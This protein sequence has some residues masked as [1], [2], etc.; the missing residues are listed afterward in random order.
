MKSFEILDQA[1]ARDTECHKP[2]V[3]A[4]IDI[5][6]MFYEESVSYLKRLEN[7]DK[8]RHTKGP[9]L[10]SPPVDIKEYA[11]LLPIV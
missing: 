4:N 2:M 5:F 10:A 3:N 11:H 1:K 9:G 7:L 8:V 6:E